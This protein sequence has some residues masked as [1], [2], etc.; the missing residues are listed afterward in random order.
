M[1]RD[2]NLDGRVVV[3]WKT[4]EWEP[5]PAIGGEDTGLMCAPSARA[6]EPARE[7]TC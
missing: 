1:T 6:P 2:W 5:Y 3:D 7:P 4:C